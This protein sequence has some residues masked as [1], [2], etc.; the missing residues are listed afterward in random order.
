MNYT[1]KMKKK[2]IYYINA[3]TITFNQPNESLLN[4]SI[5]SLKPKLDVCKMKN[6]TEHMQH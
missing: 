1:I 4:K 5:N 2:Y 3:F 6:I